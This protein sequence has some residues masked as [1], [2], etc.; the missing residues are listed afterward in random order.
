MKY[1]LLIAFVLQTWFLYSQEEYEP[2]QARGE[3]PQQILQ[4]NKTSYNQSVDTVRGT[5]REKKD[6]Q[7]FL[8]KTNYNLGSLFKSGE[9]LF[10][11]DFSKYVNKIGNELLK[12]YPDL[13]KKIKFYVVKSPEVNASSTQHGYLFVNLGLIAQVENEAQLA[14]VLAHEIIHYT[15]KHNIKSFIESKNADRNKGNYRGLSREKQRVSF[16]AYS[17]EHE[18]EA[19][20]KGFED[21]YLKAGY[22]VNEAISVF[23]VLLYSYL[24][25]DE[26]KFDTTFFNDKY[27]NLSS[28]CLVKNKNNI[29]A[30]EDYDDKNH[31]HPNIKKRREVFIEYIAN[32]EIEEGV[33]YKH[34]ENNF[35]E[36]QKA[37]R[38]ELSNLYVRN[39]DYTKSI[40][41][42]YLLLLR[43]P[44]DIY[45]KRNIAY[46][47]YALSKYKTHKNINNIVPDASKIEGES[48]QLYQIFR[49]IDKIDLNVLALKY[50]W[51]LYSNTSDEQ[52][53]KQYKDLLNDLVY[54]NKIYYEDFAKEY[55]EDSVVFVELSEKE[56][57][58]L[59]KYAK[60]KYNKRKLKSESNYDNAL[61]TSL[62]DLL[63]DTSFDEEFESLSKQA[64]KEIE[65]TDSETEN[66][67]FDK[68]R[69]KAIDTAVTKLLVASPLYE[70][71]DVDQK[72]QFVLSEEKKQVYM[73][74]LKE[75][76]QLTNVETEIID[77][78][79]VNDIDQFNRLALINSWL[80]E[81]TRHQD[82]KNFWEIY[83][84]QDFLVDDVMKDL[85]KRYISLSGVYT[86]EK[87]KWNVWQYFYVI[88]TH[89]SKVVLTNYSNTNTKDYKAPLKSFLYDSFINLTKQY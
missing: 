69:I 74:I 15:E 50:S 64:K 86:N 55:V 38:Y 14:F 2:V 3:I 48:Q 81:F 88:D 84:S 25:V 5:Y 45:L 39:L 47:L 20:K 19:D 21:F 53:K 6:K 29:T 4:L 66:N 23:D 41:N 58:K 11:D 13:Q 44:D 62:V 1:I 42:S 40:Y 63:S 9:I 16:L 71:Y 12:D 78:T 26:V 30:I 65:Q 80:L 52:F 73:D 31:T 56:Y 60:I 72:E 37:A 59:S 68:H 7:E 18:M 17:K 22:D 43:N 57:Q 34:G 8:L 10:G 49:T 51:N 36:I 28:E 61:N 24:P 54:Q 76:A 32:N 33:K 27:F 85:G 83:T 87:Y 46:S 89:T 79:E 70:K 82:F 75:I 67:T 77:I 35:L